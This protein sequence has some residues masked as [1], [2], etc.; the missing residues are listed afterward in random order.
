MITHSRGFTG[1]FHW[2][3]SS[4]ATRKH[5][6]LDATRLNRGSRPMAATPATSSTSR[7]S[8]LTADNNANRAIVPDGGSGVC[9][10]GNASDAI[11]RTKPNDAGTQCTAPEDFAVNFGWVSPKPRMLAVRPAAARQASRPVP[12]HRTGPRNRS[13]AKVIAISSSPNPHKIRFLFSFRRAFSS[14]DSVRSSISSSPCPIVF[15]GSRSV[16]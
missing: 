1:G 5:Y 7:P 3:A 9:R 13:R 8:F 6:I 16:T 2:A 14:G 15:T 10:T 12:D 4:R 11:V